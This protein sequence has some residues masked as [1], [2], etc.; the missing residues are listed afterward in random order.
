MAVLTQ[1]PRARVRCRMCGSPLPRG[2]SNI[3][4]TCVKAHFWYCENCVELVPN[5]ERE[6]HHCFAGRQMDIKNFGDDL[7]F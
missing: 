3:C 5:T 4:A 6:S 7:P 1:R 2:Q